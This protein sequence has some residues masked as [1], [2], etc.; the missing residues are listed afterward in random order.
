MTGC[1]RCHSLVVRERF[2]DRD[3]EMHASRF[4]GWRCVICGSIFD[5]LILAHQGARPE[6]KR[7][8]S[9]HKK[10]PVFVWLAKTAGSPALCENGEE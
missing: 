6:P 8:H 2:M 4:W 5:P 3:S 9:R 7:G 1:P 10:S